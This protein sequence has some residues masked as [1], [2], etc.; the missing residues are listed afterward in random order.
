VTRRKCE[1]VDRLAESY[2][3]FVGGDLRRSHTTN[4]FD[5]CGGDVLAYLRC[6]TR[7]REPRDV[8]KRH[9]S[10]NTIVLGF[11]VESDLACLFDEGVR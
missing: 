3:Y 8:Y 10:R 11:F 4:S 1:A 9:I 7:L 2:D 5:D 6:A